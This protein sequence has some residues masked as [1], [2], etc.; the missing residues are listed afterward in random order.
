MSDNNDKLYKDNEELIQNNPQLFYK[1]LYFFF[2]KIRKTDSIPYKKLSTERFEELGKK[3]TGVF[4]T[5]QINFTFKRE[6]F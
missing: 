1:D 6:E 3:L 4:K 5:N 2:R